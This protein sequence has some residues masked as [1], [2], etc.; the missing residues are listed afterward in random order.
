MLDFL[1][2]AGLP[3]NFWFLW[4]GTVVNR[5]GGF[6]VPFL[7]LYLT[8]Q[9]AIPISQ[10]A[11]VVSLFG[12]GTFLA[13]LVGGELAD[14]L[15]RRPVML[16]SF[17][18][19]PA[20]MLMV[21]FAGAL[22]VIAPATLLL[23]FFTDLYRPAVSASIAD[24]VPSPDR[25]RAYGYLY[26]AINIGAAAAPILA[27][28]MAVRSYQLLFIGDALTTLVFGLIVL[29]AVVETRPA[30]METAQSVSLGTRLAGLRSEPL[31]VAFAGLAFLFGIVY[32]QGFVTL[33][34]DMSA[35][36]LAPDQYGLAIALN[37]GLI[38]VLGL[39][40]SNSAP[41]WPR[42]TAMAISAVLLAAGFGL[43]FVATTLPIYAV[44]VAIWTLGEI[45][46]ATIAPAV[47]ADL[48]PRDK[49]GLYQGIF[50]SSWG[51]AFFA[52]PALGGWIFENN[53]A[54]TL[55]S[56][57]AL[58]GLAVA[59]GFLAMARPAARRASRVRQGTP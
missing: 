50:G 6:V 42:F 19:T 52:G 33:P 56:L 1:R 31:L 58:I 28:Y 26:W 21:G 36:G 9:R 37:G 11:L 8:S 27:G 24:M 53:G 51:L 29:A 15:G 18:V 17:F 40:V 39:P 38:V 47:V 10:A 48:S 44:T 12:A 16:I 49:R 55:W 22:L 23:G 25:P 2:G 14:R 59:A 46:G 54:A 30:E 4:A 35:A 20:V 13:N 41:R 5:L 57:C 34:L 3:R 45:G 7:T 32:S 43:T